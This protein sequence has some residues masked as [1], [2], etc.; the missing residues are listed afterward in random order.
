MH[1]ALGHGFLFSLLSLQICLVWYGMVCRQIATTQL[2]PS[3]CNCAFDY[4][5]LFLFWFSSPSARLYQLSSCSRVSCLLS[6]LK[7]VVCSREWVSVCGSCYIDIPSKCRDFLKHPICKKISFHIDDQF[8][9]SKTNLRTAVW[10]SWSKPTPFDPSSIVLRS[11]LR[12][13]TQYS[14]VR[15]GIFLRTFSVLFFC[16][17]VPFFFRSSIKSVIC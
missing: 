7:V 9:G 1:I 15:S 2:F 8:C 5:F 14:S 17:V 3:I 12:R 16:Y 6:L 4:M 11:S 10:V 13:Y